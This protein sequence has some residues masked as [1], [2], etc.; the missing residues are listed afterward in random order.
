VILKILIP[1]LMLII[2]VMWACLPFYWGSRKSILH[3]PSE[4]DSS[5][6]STKQI[7]ECGLEA[8]D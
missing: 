7:E 3:K 4:R 2:V 8:D 5:G 1:G 6:L